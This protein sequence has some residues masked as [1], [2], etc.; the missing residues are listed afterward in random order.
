MEML[1]TCTCYSRLHWRWFRSRVTLLL[2]NV[3]LSCPCTFQDLTEPHVGSSYSTC[4]VYIGTRVAFRLEQ[5]S[6]LH[7]TMCHIFIGPRGITTI[8]CMSFFYL[9][10]YH[11][12]VCLCVSILLGHVSRPELPTRLFLFDHMAGRIC[13]TCLVCIGPHVLS[14]HLHVSFT[15]LSICQIL[16]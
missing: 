12:V 15:G 5:V 4:Q 1:S 14:C 11:D 2:H 9:T 7:W 16:I 10:T 3:A 13:T 8:P 6:L